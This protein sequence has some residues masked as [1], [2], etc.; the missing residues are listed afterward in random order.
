[1]KV[2]NCAEIIIIGFFENQLRRTIIA[3]SPRT[4]AGNY[5]YLFFWLDSIHSFILSHST[6][7]ATLTSLISRVEQ[8]RGHIRKSKYQRQ[9]YI[10]ELFIW[11]LNSVPIDD[12]HSQSFL[13]IHPHLPSTHTFHPLIHHPHA[14]HQL[15]TNKSFP[16]V[17]SATH[18]YF[19]I[20]STVEPTQE[21]G[22]RVKLISSK[23]FICSTMSD[24]FRFSSSQSLL[25]LLRDIQRERQTDRLSGRWLLGEGLETLQL[26]E[27]HFKIDSNIKWIGAVETGLQYDYVLVHPWVAAPQWTRMESGTNK[28]KFTDFQ[29][30]W[31]TIF[32]LFGCWTSIACT[33]TTTTIRPLQS[34]VN[35]TVLPPTVLKSRV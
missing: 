3:S 1:M 35:C 5:F 19:L 10:T 17:S 27:F 13:S 8:K 32:Y 22:S 25:P 18:K 30:D 23:N 9:I 24:A 29:F 6:C 15:E 33:T 28:I 4:S 26:D 20:S 31:V 34:N 14:L 12:Y 16:S 11:R 2:F 7:T 21:R